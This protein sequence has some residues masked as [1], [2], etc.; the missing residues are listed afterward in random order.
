MR[1]ERELAASANASDRP[2]ERLR[3]STRRE[4]VIEDVPWAILGIPCDPGLRSRPPSGE[5]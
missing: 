4:P 1:A 2:D 5:K 3:R